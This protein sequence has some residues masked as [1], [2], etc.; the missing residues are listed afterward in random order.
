MERKKAERK[1][2]IQNEETIRC[3]THW[4]RH[5]K[6]NMKNKNKLMTEAFSKEYGVSGT[7]YLVRVNFQIVDLFQYLCR[8]SR[9]FQQ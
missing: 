9:R 1:T 4:K 2:E 6:E 5:P 3:Q 7:T 8:R